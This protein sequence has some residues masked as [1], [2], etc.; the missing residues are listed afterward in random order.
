MSKLLHTASC[1]SQQ[2]L[3]EVM[4][5]LWALLLL[6]LKLV[7]ENVNLVLLLCQSFIHCREM[8]THHAQLTLVATCRRLQLVLTHNKLSL[9]RHHLE[10][11]SHKWSN[12]LDSSNQFEW[13]SSHF[14]STDINHSASIN[15]DLRC[16]LKRWPTNDR[17]VDGRWK[18]QRCSDQHLSVRSENGMKSTEWFCWLSG[19]QSQLED[20]IR[21]TG[22]LNFYQ[23]DHG[24]WTRHRWVCVYVCNN[25]VPYQPVTLVV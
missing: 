5:D 11:L 25:K 3:V 1:T 9:S 22:N 20:S 16:R 10:I 4:N 2:Q 19:F 24:C 21:Q 6:L 8:L 7:L 18:K 17:L 13:S 14:I 15:N 12:T 23:R